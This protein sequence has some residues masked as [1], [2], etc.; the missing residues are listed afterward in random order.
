LVCGK[1]KWGFLLVSGRIPAP[2]YRRVYEDGRSAGNRHLVLYYLPGG[3]GIRLGVSVSRRLG[4][5]HVRNRLKRRV[6]EA[7]RLLVPNLAKE[8]QVVFIV[9]R[10]SVASTFWDLLESMRDLMRRMG[11]L[12]A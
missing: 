4:K 5:A 12:D 11:L 6:K 2:S 8:G 1:G 10:G 7:F 3:P 9:K